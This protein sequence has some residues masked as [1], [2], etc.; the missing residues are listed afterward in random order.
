[1]KVFDTLQEVN[2]RNYSQPNRTWS[3]LLLDL[4]RGL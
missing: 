4:T 2:R 3:N 1:M